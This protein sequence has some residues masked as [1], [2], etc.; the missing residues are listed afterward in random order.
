MN[1]TQLRQ[2]HAA[3]EETFLAARKLYYSNCDRISEEIG[4]HL[5]Q[6]REAAGINYSVMGRLMKAKT[7]RTYCNQLENGILDKD[8]TRRWY[9]VPTMLD[10]VLI[11]ETICAQVSGLSRELANAVSQS[12]VAGPSEFHP[13]SRTGP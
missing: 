12:R 5:K 1:I 2:D 11:Y 10:S 13:Y 8:G 7:P 3:L 6:I 4:K 9:S